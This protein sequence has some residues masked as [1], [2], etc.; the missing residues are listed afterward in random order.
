MFYIEKT[1]RLMYF[2]LIMTIKNISN[3]KNC[4]WVPGYW[5]AATAYIPQGNV[6]TYPDLHP[7]R[8][9]P[10]GLQ[11]LNIEDTAQAVIILQSSFSWKIEPSD[12]TPLLKNTF[13]AN[14]FFPKRHLNRLMIDI[15]KNS[16]FFTCQV[17]LL[18]FN[19]SSLFS[20]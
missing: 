7:C 14:A 15:C 19:A 16:F 17:C 10:Q 11:A 5:M 8:V 20:C 4:V 3:V 13:P 9:L 1:I 6:E 12:T 2:W 18:E